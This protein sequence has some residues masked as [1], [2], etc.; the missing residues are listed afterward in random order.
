MFNNFIVK[1]DEESIENNCTIQTL[2]VL[3]LFPITNLE[4]G[5]EEDVTWK[6][7]SNT[8]AEHTHLHITWVLVFS[9]IIL[10]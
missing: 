6:A 9:Y 1:D 5:L 7:T 10:G 2:R 3:L 8:W 4:P